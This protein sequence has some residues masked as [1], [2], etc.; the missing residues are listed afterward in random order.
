MKDYKAYNDWLFGRWAPIYDIFELLLS[1][2]R[3]EVVQE[4]NTAGKSILDVATGT[5]SLALEL[6][7]SAKKVVGID[8]SDKMLEEAKG[9]K[10]GDN[11]TFLQMDAS[12]MVFDDEEFDVVTISL[13]LH[14]MPIDIRSAVLKEVQRVLKKDGKL[15]IFEHDL[16]KNELLGQVSANIINILESRY[17]LDFVNSDF[18]TYLQSLGF[19]VEKKISYILDHFRLLTVSK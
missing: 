7:H 6:S 10:G 14:D 15:Y 9:K 12:Q 3:K 1:G 2:I 11:L 4:I 5:G 18:E 13:G 16:P 19:T 17:F 8:L